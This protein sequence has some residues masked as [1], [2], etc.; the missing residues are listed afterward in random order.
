MYLETFG[1]SWN[2]LSHITLTHNLAAWG[3]GIYSNRS[4]TGTALLFDQNRAFSLGGGL[5]GASF[6]FYVQN[7]TFEHNHAGA[8]GGVYLSG[9]AGRF[10]Q[11]RFTKNTSNTTGGA[12]NGN[13]GGPTEL[14]GSNL[15]FEEN[16]AQYG[17]AIHLQSGVYT[18]S[19][20]TFISNAALAETFWPLPY[21]VSSGGIGG[22]IYNMGGTINLTET[23]C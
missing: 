1:F 6:P 15:W 19:S 4:F 9:A 17:G 20:T 5:M 14:T 13:F 23:T 8:G 18:I 2:Q 7:S 3:G 16:R 12:I 22:A 11:T 21:P 10:H